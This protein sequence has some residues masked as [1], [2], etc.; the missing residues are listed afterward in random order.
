MSLKY[1]LLSKP[2]PLEERKS[3]QIK[4]AAIFGFVVFAFLFVLRPFEMQGNVTES[5]GICAVSGLLSFATI[6]FNFFILFPIF[7]NFFKESHWTIGREIIWTLII[8][9]SIATVNLVAGSFIWNQTISFNGWLR[10]I[11]AT[12]TI[13]VAPATLSIIINQSRLLK[14]YRNGAGKMSEDLPKLNEKIVESRPHIPEEFAVLENE[15]NLVGPGMAAADHKIIETTDP[16]AISFQKFTIEA[17]NE[18][19]NLSIYPADFLAATSADNYVKVYHIDGEKLKTA[20]LRTSLKKM[21]ENIPQFPSFFRCHR[22]AIVN[23]AAV[24]KVSGTA[25]GYRLHLKLLQEA[26]PVSRNLN[27]EIKTKLRAIRP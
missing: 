10:M 22:T 8:I 11:F 15:P 7:P 2:Y 20:M 25:Q 12:A 23:V 26:I 21:E 9:L 1:G 4:L 16:E 14:K 19:D 3:H 5:L 13:G 24:I 17:D 18:K 27:A 6:L